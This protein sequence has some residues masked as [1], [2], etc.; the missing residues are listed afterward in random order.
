[1]VRAIACVGHSQGGMM[2]RWYVK[3]LA[4]D[5]TVAEIVGLSP[6]NHG[7]TN[8]LAPPLDRLGVCRAC[9]QQAAGSPFITRLNRG[10]ETPGRIDY[11]QIQTRYDEVVTPFASAF[12]DGPRSQVTNVLLQDR[13]PLDLFEHA[14][15]SYDPAAIQWVDEALARNGPAPR[16]FKPKCL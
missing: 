16:G 13:C 12:L 9:G 10:D 15:I 1:V 8:P 4:G 7:T 14:L 5:R 6:S 2:P 3:H 11:T